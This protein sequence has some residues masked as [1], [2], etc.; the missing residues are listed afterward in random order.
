[1]P[2]ESLDR[3]RSIDKELGDPTFLSRQRLRPV[4]GYR[5]VSAVMVGNL[6]AEA[7][8]RCRAEPDNL[9]P[10]EPALSRGDRLRRHDVA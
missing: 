7:A 9:S 10:G 6:V 2:H 8:V 5:A 3:H 4:S 1:M